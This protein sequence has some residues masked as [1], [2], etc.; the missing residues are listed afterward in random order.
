MRSYSNQEAVERIL[1]IFKLP[2]D[3]P[4]FPNNPNDKPRIHRRLDLL[5]APIEV[6]WC[7]VVGW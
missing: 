6:Y 3:S 7:T 5:F 4:S 1:T 2:Q